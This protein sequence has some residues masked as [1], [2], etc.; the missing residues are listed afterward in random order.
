MARESLEFDVVIVGAGPAGLGAAC[1]LGQLARAAGTELAICVVEKGAEVGAHILSGAVLEP[2]A[3]SELFPD[4]R[5]R[6]AP[7]AT[8]VTTERFYWLFS[9]RSHRVLPAGLVPRPLHNRGNYIVS[10]GD[11]CRWLAQEA[12]ALG[13]SVLPGTA[14]TELLY[15]GAVVRGVATGDLGVTRDGAAKPNYQPGYELRA[16]YVVFAEGCRGS[17]GKTLETRFD[18]R[19][20]CDPQH[21]GIG[22]KEIWQVAPD[23]Q[24][25]GEVVHTAG[26]PLDNGTEGG[27][28]LYHAGGGQAFVGLVIALSYRNPY[29]DPFE[30]FQ[31]WKHHPVIRE[32]LAGGRRIA[33]GARAVN[34]GG[35]Y[36]LPKL[37]V[38]GGL[39]VGCEAGFLNGAKVK[40]A[41]TAIKSGMLAAET[42]YEALATGDQ[43]GRELARYP[44]RVHASWIAEELTTARNF[45]AGLTRLGAFAGGALALL[46]HNVLRGRSPFT[47]R[48]PVPDH[49]RLVR[50]ADAAP[51][52]YPKPD[53][54]LSFDRLSSVFLSNTAHEE[55]Q[56]CHLR[57]ADP[58][59]PIAANLPKFA[60]PA[61]RYCP[62][63]VYEVVRDPAGQPQ[64]RI[65]AANCVHCK[66]CDIKD[67][68]ENITWVPPEGGGGPSYSGM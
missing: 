47:L 51:I 27:G 43:G 67:P 3:L 46:E 30:E 36:S 41:H 38:P 26:W 8:P 10:L 61:Q 65:N 44:E 19:A 29:L 53:G 49:A 68:A 50:A 24:R 52:D 21:F 9:E 11:L 48:N 35:W 6:G 2:R 63:A 20:H 34:K 17:L 33:Y 16:K 39:L 15:D 66:T 62:A 37:V 54:V 64:F 56:P 40:G 55:N 1:R 31:R 12:E 4:W 32:V 7:P 57:L 25:P 28:F 42:I 14:A 59:V 22:F 13:V 18:L 5:A 58:A 23:L 60:E 45:S